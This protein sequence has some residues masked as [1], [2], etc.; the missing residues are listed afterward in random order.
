MIANLS[1][2]LQQAIW[3]PKDVLTQTRR[4]RLRLAR[5]VNEHE[6][7]KIS[8]EK[9]KTYPGERRSERLLEEL[10]AMSS[11]SLHVVGEVAL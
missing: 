10:L 8:P 5:R 6:T 7:M 11:S 9:T 2:T 4:R 1:G 3:W